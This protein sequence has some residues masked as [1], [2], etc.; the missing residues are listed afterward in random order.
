VGA[1][2]GPG[3]AQAHADSE[4]AAADTTGQVPIS[5]AGNARIEDRSFSVPATCLAPVILVHPNGDAAH[6]IALD[7]RR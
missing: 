6:Y 7:G 4:T 5:R 1:A 2:L 3:R